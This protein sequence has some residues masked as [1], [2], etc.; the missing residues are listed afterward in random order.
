MKIQGSYTP[1]MGQSVYSNLKQNISTPARQNGPEHTAQT[2][3][4][5]AKP[6]QARLDAHQL[7][8]DMRIKASLKNRDEAIKSAQ[9]HLVKAYQGFEAFKEQQMALNPDLD[10]SDLDVALKDGSII[11]TGVKSQNG[12]PVTGNQI[13]AIQEALSD[14][15]ELTKNLEYALSDLTKSV[16]TAGL[17]AEFRVDIEKLDSLEHNKEDLVQNGA[18]TLNS[19]IEGFLDNFPRRPSHEDVR[20]TRKRELLGYAP[21]AQPQ[22]EWD[23]SQALDDEYFESSFYH[24]LRLMGTIVKDDPRNHLAGTDAY[25]FVETKA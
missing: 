12:E 6:D 21:V 9:Y 19:F 15:E 10:L 3:Q 11:M 14:N 8:N 18:F 4:K 22:K 16:Y 24:H 1:P 5:L 20:E 25:Q 13:N 23:F 17:Y 2:M 7:I